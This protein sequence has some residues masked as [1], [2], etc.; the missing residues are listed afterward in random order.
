MPFEIT[1]FYSELIV[2]IILIILLVLGSTIFVLKSTTAETDSQ[3]YFFLGI[4]LFGYFF[5][6]TR[7]FFLFTDFRVESD[8]IYLLCWKI[9]SVSTLIALVFFELIVEKYLVK[10]RY[11]FTSIAVI[12]VI[13]M[14]ILNLELAR[15][16]VIILSPI[17]LFDIIGIYFWVALKNEGEPRSKALNSMASI[18]IIVLGTLIDGTL[19]ASLIGFDTGVFGAALMIVGFGWYFKT[20]YKN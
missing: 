9:A 12:G 1:L 10:T 5:A 3:K 13:L 18:I 14:L 19:F 4:S 6:L 20:N 2:K 17:L 11:V 7:L 16:F 8:P 15:I